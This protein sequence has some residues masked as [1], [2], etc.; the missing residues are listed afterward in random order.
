MT[1]AK[2]T[3]EK[4]LSSMWLGLLSFVLGIL[5]GVPALVQ[6]LRG[7]RDIR[8]QRGWLGGRGYAMIGI[9]TGLLGSAASV[10]LVALAIDRVR[11]AADRAH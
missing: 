3:S 8:R 7:L 2:P 6:G 9:G 11:D 1:A 5:A 10:V 4:A